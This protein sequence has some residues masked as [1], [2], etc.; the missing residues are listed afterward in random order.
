MKPNFK[1]VD[2]RKSLTA[3]STESTKGTTCTCSTE[4]DW[5]PSEKIKV[6]STYTADD[7]KD[8]ELWSRWI[9]VSRVFGSGSCR[10]MVR[11]ELGS[12]KKTSCV[13]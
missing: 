5:I 8:M 3:E 9:E 13:I 10:I 7:L 11:K 12:E 4:Q 2:F 6:K 1:N